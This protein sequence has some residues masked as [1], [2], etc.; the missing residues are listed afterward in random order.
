MSWHLVLTSLPRP[1]H[2]LHENTPTALR[3]AAECLEQIRAVG[4]TRKRRKHIL[5]NCQATPL[6][7]D[8]VADKFV[9]R[10]KE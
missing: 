2:R 8:N 6:V 7:C 10:Y 1:R 9:S 4:A 3:A 5:L